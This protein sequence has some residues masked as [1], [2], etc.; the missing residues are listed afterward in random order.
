MEGYGDTKRNFL[1][2][3]EHNHKVF[4]SGIKHSWSLEVNLIITTLA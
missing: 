2:K 3:L 4:S 1:N